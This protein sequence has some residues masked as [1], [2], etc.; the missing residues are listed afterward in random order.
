MNQNQDFA[1]EWNFCTCTSAKLLSCLHLFLTQAGM[2]PNIFI[3]NFG[4]SHI[5][6]GWRTCFGPKRTGLLTRSRRANP[7]RAPAALLTSGKRVFQLLP[8]CGACS[9]GMSRR[10]HLVAAVLMTALAGPA[11]PSDAGVTGLGHRA[12]VVD[13]LPTM[14]V[15]TN[16]TVARVPPTHAGLIMEGVNHALYGYGLGSQMLFGEGFEEPNITDCTAHSAP[17]YGPFP[18]QWSLTNGGATVTSEEAEVFTGKQALRVDG[19]AQLLNAGT[20]P[21]RHTLKHR[22]GRCVPRCGSVE[23]NI[24]AQCYFFLRRRR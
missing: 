22:R 21:S 20:Y 4:I 3:I 15:A 1:A 16:V 19:T 24:A 23:G 9:C 7:A 18:N 2:A 8:V 14:S 17:C 5:T 10:H 11:R 6:V 12:K 13:V